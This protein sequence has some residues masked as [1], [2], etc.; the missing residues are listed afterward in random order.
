MFPSEGPQTVVR[1]PRHGA[2]V[3]LPRKPGT[4]CPPP[5]Q[6]PFP[7]WNPTQKEEAILPDLHLPLVLSWLPNLLSLGRGGRPSILPSGQAEKCP[8]VNEGLEPGIW[9]G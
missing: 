6:R 9:T 2:R 8:R 3:S 4:L 1:G 5:T 7:S